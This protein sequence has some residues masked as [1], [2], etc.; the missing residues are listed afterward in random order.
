MLRGRRGKALQQS[1]IAVPY[2][3]AGA[4]QL[5]HEGRKQ[6]DTFFTAQRGN[7]TLAHLARQRNGRMFDECRAEDC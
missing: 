7:T 1:L 6:E 2:V 5:A 3:K 4:A